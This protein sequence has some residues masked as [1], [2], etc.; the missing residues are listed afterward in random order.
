MM[1]VWPCAGTA[2]FEVF[3]HGAI[4]KPLYFEI[5]CEMKVWDNNDN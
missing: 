3:F 2:V 5:V 1:K 4:I